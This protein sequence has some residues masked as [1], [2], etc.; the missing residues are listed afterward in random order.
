ML[1][2]A[3]PWDFILILIVLAIVV[4]WRGAVRIRSLMRRESLTSVDRIALYASTIAFQWLATAIILW[5]ASAHA[6]RLADLGLALPSP[7][8]TVIVGVALSALITLN[9]A[10]SIRRLASLPSEKQGFMR[11]LT[12]KLMPQ[13]APERLAFFA[14]VTTVALCEET[15]YR[16][17]IQRLFL[18]VSNGSIAIAILGAAVFFALAHLYQG[19]RGLIVTFFAGAIFSAVRAWTGSLIPTM[20]AHFVADL[21]VG[22]LAPRLLTVRALPP[23]D[24]VPASADTNP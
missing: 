6:D 23:A 2:S 22:L 10:A 8:L 3:L 11:A 16:G 13:T 1:P 15:I 17:F 12:I 9:Q 14:L 4:P 21:S 20:I 19:R 7:W 18:N 24:Q 5:R